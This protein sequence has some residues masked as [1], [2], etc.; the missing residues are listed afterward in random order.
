MDGANGL[1]RQPAH[2]RE[3]S[4]ARRRVY[5]SE[6]HKTLP[7]PFVGSAGRVPESSAG[8][9]A[10]L[11]ACGGMTGVTG[12]VQE[13]GMGGTKSPVSAWT[14]PADAIFPGVLLAH[15]RRVAGLLGLLAQ[16]PDPRDPRGVR[17]TL[18]GALALAASAVLAGA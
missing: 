1:V 10:R 2:L 17:Y 15:S 18:I 12:V 11:T 6:E 13:A 7:R 16:A 9:H 4:C 14:T 3:H 5:L 8:G